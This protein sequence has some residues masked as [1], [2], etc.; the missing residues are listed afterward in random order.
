MTRS[1]STKRPS[2]IPARRGS[3]RIIA[4]KWRRR[5]LRVEDR[6]DL[7]PTPDRVREALFSWLAPVI[8]GSRCLD[9]FAGSGA[10]GFEAASRGAKHVTMVE[11]DPG[12]AGSLEKHRVLLSATE[13][14]VVQ[15]DAFRWLAATD[16]EFDI[17]F[18]DPPFA[19]YDVGVIC[20][21]LE[22][23]GLVAPSGFV[24]L[25]HS[26]KASVPRLPKNWEWYRSQR[27]G[28][29]R[30]DLALRDSPGEIA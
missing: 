2:G 3:V 17:I 1:G 16:A 18:L 10:L 28:R 4:G 6:P 15:E 9:L 7:R 23:K 14:T 27:A 22:N 30:Y 19:T 8:Q 21:A 24:Y 11:V 26:V 20:T 13:V 12:L 5:R 25:E 29:L